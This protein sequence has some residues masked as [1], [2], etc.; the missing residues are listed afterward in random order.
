LEFFHAILNCDVILASLPKFLVTPKNRTIVYAMPN[1]EKGVKQSL[2]TN[3]K[4]LPTQPRPK[5]PLAAVMLV[6]KDLA[7][8]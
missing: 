3:E 8:V 6:T 1:Q 4:S 5:W 7:E 2:E